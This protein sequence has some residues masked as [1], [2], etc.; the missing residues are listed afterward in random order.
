MRAIDSGPRIGAIAPIAIVTTRAST[1]T[2]SPSVSLPSET[3]SQ[4]SAATRSTIA[5][6]AAARANAPPTRAHRL[7]AIAPATA[8]PN[9]TRVAS[10]P[11]AITATCA[12]NAS[13][14]ARS[15]N[16]AYT[17]STRVASARRYS[18][19][20]LRAVP[21][22]RA[23]TSSVCAGAA[24][25]RAATPRTHASCAASHTMPTSQNPARLAI[26][27]N[28]AVVLAVNSR[29]RA[30]S[31]PHA[32]AVHHAGARSPS[33]R[34]QA[35]NAATNST[36]L[37]SQTADIAIPYAGPGTSS[38]ISGAASDSPYAATVTIAHARTSGR[39]VSLAPRAIITA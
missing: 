19:I 27:G 6:A 11:I 37:T 24:G 16:A 5:A 12:S 15:A 22:S 10:I 20:A 36:P 9:R 8:A 28:E 21:A 7:S 38:A 26:T 31:A 33:E 13:A 17:D 39:A 3:T 29:T 14:I 4:P 18:A 25:A 35:A 30:A 2:S 32:S 23:G 34:Y 1:S